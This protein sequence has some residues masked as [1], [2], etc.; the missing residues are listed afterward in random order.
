MPDG[1]KHILVADDNAALSNVIRFNLEAVG[2]K[3]T[4]A[5]NGLEAWNLL[6]ASRYDMLVTDHQM[7]EMSGLELC[8]RIS[9]EPGL[10]G[11]PIIMLTAKRIELENAE[12][13]RL[14][15]ILQLLPKPFSPRELAA[16]VMNA[17]APALMD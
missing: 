16:S 13:L 17:L 12:F 7:P 5:R 15:G 6:Q 10:A 11:L 4:Q 3:V 1:Q 9:G 14:R 8:E 2:F